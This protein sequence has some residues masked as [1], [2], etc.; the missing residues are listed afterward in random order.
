MDGQCWAR[1]APYEWCWD[2]AGYAAH[3]MVH[4][5]MTECICGVAEWWRCSVWTC[6]GHNQQQWLHNVLHK[7]WGECMAWGHGAWGLKGTRVCIHACTHVEV[8]GGPCS[9]R[10]GHLTRCKVTICMPKSLAS[11]HPER[12]T[13]AH[14]SHR[15]HAILHWLSLIRSL[16]HSTMA[17]LW[18]ARP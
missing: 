11:Y 10:P 12:R 5:T 1:C 8:C 13:T 7:W 4:G 9:R 3:G 16:V 17:S 18:H 14:T 6:S 2:R 15:A